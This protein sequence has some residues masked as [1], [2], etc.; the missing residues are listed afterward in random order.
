MQKFTER[1]ILILFYAYPYLELS[2]Y[3]DHYAMK[4]NLDLKTAGYIFYYYIS[5][6]NIL[7][8]GQLLFGFDIE[9]LLI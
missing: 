4:N 8:V 5:K 9:Y 6:N 2:R 7:Q 1:M 3:T